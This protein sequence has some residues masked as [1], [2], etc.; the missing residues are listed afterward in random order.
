MLHN[1]KHTKNSFHKTGQMFRGIKI[2][3]K[4]DHFFLWHSKQNLGSS[5]F[6]CHNFKNQMWDNY[7]GQLFNPEIFPNIVLMLSSD[8]VDDEL[9][10]LQMVEQ[11]FTYGN[12][13]S[14]H[15]LPL[16]PISRNLVKLIQSPVKTV[17]NTALNCI[18]QFLDS[19]TSSTANLVNN[20]LL[21]VVKRIIDN[22]EYFDSIRNLI[23]ICLII[24]RYRPACI[25]NQVGFTALTS[26]IEFLENRDRKDI[27]K[28]ISNIS[29]FMAHFPDNFG[30]LL[31][32]LNGDNA[33][34]SDTLF[35]LICNILR[36]SRELGEK[37]MNIIKNITQHLNTEK[38]FES[39]IQSLLNF[40]K[41]QNGPALII[42]TEF[43]FSLLINKSSQQTFI[44]ILQIISCLLPIPKIPNAKE[45]WNLPGNRNI[46]RHNK[47]FASYIQPI[48][49]DVFLQKKSLNP[50][51]ILN[52]SQAIRLSKQPKTISE[53]MLKTMIIYSQYDDFLPNILYLLL[54]F[55]NVSQYFGTYL[56][57]FIA[58]KTL[59]EDNKRL[60]WFNS[61]IKN[62]QK[63]KEFSLAPKNFQSY[64]FN[65]TK[66][67]DLVSLVTDI[68]EI[69]SFEFL[70]SDSFQYLKDLII[71]SDKKIFLTNDFS[72]LIDKMF[73]LVNLITIQ[74]EEDIYRKSM[75]NIINQISSLQI[76]LSDDTIIFSDWKNTE[77]LLGFEASYNWKERDIFTS[78]IREAH[79]NAGRLS[80]IIHL[81]DLNEIPISNIAMLQRAFKTPNYQRCEFSING[82]KISALDSLF[83]T[84]IINNYISKKPYHNVFPIDLKIK[85]DDEPETLSNVVI[86]KYSANQ[87]INDILDILYLIKEK[88]DN[89]PIFNLDFD[90]KLYSLIDSPFLAVTGLAPAIQ[91]VA[92]YPKIFSYKLRSLVYSS[93]S[94]PLIASLSAVSMKISNDHFDD[95][96]SHFKISINRNTIFNDGCLLI[97]ALQYPHVYYDISFEGEEGVGHGLTREFFSIMGL[98]FTKVERNMWRNDSNSEYSMT[99]IG[100]FP[101]VGASLTLFKT[102][103]I[104]C[105][106]AIEM[107]YNIP[108]QLSIPFFKIFKGEKVTF[109]EIDSQLAYSIRQSDPDALEGINFVY[110]G[111]NLPLIPNGAEIFVN[112]ENINDYKQ[113]VEKMTI[114]KEAIDAFKSG[115]YRIINPGLENL[116]TAEEFVRLI[117][118]D[119]ICDISIEELISNVDVGNG[120]KKDDPIIINLF[121]IICEMDLHE[122]ALFLKF[123]TGSERLPIG[124]I[125]K[126]H[127]HLTISKKIPGENSKFKIDDILAS[128]MTCT[129]HLKLPPY[130]NK[131]ILK[132]K[133]FYA[134]TEGQNSFLFT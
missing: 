27:F 112:K 48:L 35:N 76:R 40:A 33:M 78:Q 62:I 54:S 133:L 53:E 38:Q 80:E 117:C 65:I 45:Y 20:G 52:L 49:M 66:Y 111:T 36:N 37:D 30:D 58:S 91:I 6:S 110:P 42:D 85:T 56:V 67:K 63:S 47:K 129:N 5:L 115:F 16:S 43:D 59:P 120:Y 1:K 103:G 98:E 4:F 28:I 84:K 102:L 9:V 113:L 32:Y 124:G 95:F 72:P 130:S 10:G 97:N 128:A 41:S 14:L 125:S 29:P 7:F 132:E 96:L 74:P 75:Y 106:K 87:R 90:Q 22:F 123:V 39:I 116:L 108:L 81:P 2:S 99:S 73:E 107:G 60:H 104:L 17:Y 93:L 109:E 50:L 79:K 18:R 31:P 131:S 71:Q 64:L 12:D 69:S 122:K 100:L 134:I 77:C 68:K 8:N 13:E 21:P 25:A 19:H 61:K 83:R 101:C 126:L 26:K 114:N 51:I 23:K 3:E 119:D 92:K 15:E 94:F 46:T 105:G 44:S 34:F 88:N 86:L 89:I 70:L 57:K 127:P 82:K 121:E 55:S 24:S 118:G 11:I